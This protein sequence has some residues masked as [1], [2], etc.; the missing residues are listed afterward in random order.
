M[1]RPR[2]D[3]GPGRKLGAVLDKIASFSR[4]ASK[5]SPHGRG[6]KTCTN[7]E[8]K[9]FCKQIVWVSDWS[10]AA[11][12]IGSLSETPSTWPTAS[13]IRAARIVDFTPTA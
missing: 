5:R 6:V 2:G 11:R 10:K 8:I 7:L 4:R 1:T 9:P 3:E 13:V 12:G